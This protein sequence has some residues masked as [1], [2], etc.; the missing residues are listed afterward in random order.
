[1]VFLGS[2]IAEAIN[3][4]NQSINR[5]FAWWRYF[6]TKTRMLCQ[7]AFLFKFVFSLGNKEK[8]GKISVT[9]EAS[10]SILVSVVKWHHHENGLLAAPFHQREGLDQIRA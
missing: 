1:M 8:I 3:Q 4:I 5:S 6:T 7:N 2:K 10:N 9:I